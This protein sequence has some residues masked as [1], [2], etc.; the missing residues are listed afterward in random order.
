M[1]TLLGKLKSTLHIAKNNETRGEKT[2]IGNTDIYLNKHF[3]FNPIFVF[4]PRE[5]R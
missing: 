1:Q 3:S 4:M 5:S 2:T